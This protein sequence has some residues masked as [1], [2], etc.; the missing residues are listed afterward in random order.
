MKVIA[1]VNEHKVIAEI[2]SR[3]LAGLVG[4]SD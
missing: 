1:F 4:V 3:D 2:S